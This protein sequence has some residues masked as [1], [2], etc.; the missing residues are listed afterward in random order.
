M[1]V[2]LSG[3]KI[4]I[5]VKELNFIGRFVGLMFKGRNADNLLFNFKKE[6][7]IAI[8]SWFVFFSFLAIWLDS[9]NNVVSYRVV[10]P[11]S[12]I[13]LP[14]RKFSKLIEVPI[15]KKNKKIIDFFVGERKI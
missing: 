3:R 10:W 6:G 4:N 13:I 2:N 8:H 5:K 9:K 15:N 7:R 14:R 11:F 12:T 1:K